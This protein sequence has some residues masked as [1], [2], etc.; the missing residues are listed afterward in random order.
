[1]GR[2]AKNYRVHTGSYA[3]GLPRGTNSFGPQFPV[4]GQVRFNTETNKLEVWYLSAWNPMVHEGR[5][6]IVKDSFVGNGDESSFSMSQ[7]YQPGEEAMVLVFIGNIF[8]NAGVAYTVNGDSIDFT[9]M[10]PSGMPII[11]LHNFN[12]TRA[13]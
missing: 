1:M 11:V 3:V 13:I 5:V 2:F 8:Q 9:E 10:P 12:S 7:S 4:D 6:A